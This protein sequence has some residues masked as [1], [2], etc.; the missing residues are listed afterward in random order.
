MHKKAL[1]KGWIVVIAGFAVNLMLGTLYSWGVISSVLIDELGWT[2]TMTQI[3]YMVACAT[4]ALSMVPGGRIQDKLGPKPILMA[5]ATLAGIGF[6]FSGLFLTVTTL[7]IFFGIV[8]GAAMGIG[9]ST[10]TPAAVK[11]FDSSKRG[12]ISGIVVSGFGLAPLY[13]APLTTFLLKKYDIQ[14]TFY[15]LGVSFFIGIMIL[16]RFISN[17]SEEYIAKQLKVKSLTDS[18]SKSEKVQKNYTW[19]EVLK[20]K[21]FYMLWSM[22]CCGTFAGLLIIGQLSKIGLEQAGIQNGFILAA[23]YAIFNAS[24]RVGCGVLSDRIGRIQTLFMMFTLQVIIYIF[25][26]G[27]TSAIPLMFGVAVVGFTFGGMLTIFPATTGDYFGMKNFGMNYG[28]VITAWGVGGILGPLLGG[29]VRDI[30]GTYGFSYTAS[31][32]LSLIGAML[33]IATKLSEKQLV[34]MKKVEVVKK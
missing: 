18:I 8:F 31:A 32:V 1:S 15:F 6:I 12:V 14:T 19:R 25:F 16:S 24:G 34:N 7:T 10:A 29:I 11:W 9:Y 3:P 22:F 23:I 17:P 30:T 20:S 28:M 33:A 21:Q 4:F 5:S 27:F 2:A 13:I 26:A